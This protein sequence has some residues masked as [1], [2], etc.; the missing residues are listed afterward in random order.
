MLEHRRIKAVVIL[1]RVSTCLA[2][3]IGLIVQSVLGVYGRLFWAFSEL[4]WQNGAPGTRANEAGE[5]D[6]RQTHPFLIMR[7]RVATRFV[8]CS[9]SGIHV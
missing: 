9:R 8:I 4:P 5:A 3:L 2:Y 7:T 1:N 6:P